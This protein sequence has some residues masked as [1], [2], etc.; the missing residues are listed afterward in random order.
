MPNLQ[1]VISQL[2]S[3]K[4]NLEGQL[5]KVNEALRALSRMNSDS[6]RGGRPG[7]RTISAAGRRRIAAAQRARWAKARGEAQKPARVL[8]IS[9]RRRIAAAQRARWAEWKKQQK[10][11][12]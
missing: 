5:K 6:R 4:S 10:K 3:E 11:A 8:S 12:A 1:G 2:Q 9:A 7:R